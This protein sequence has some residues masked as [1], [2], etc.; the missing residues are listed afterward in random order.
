VHYPLCL[1]VSRRG[2]GRSGRHGVA[3]IV[4]GRA[5]VAI[6]AAAVVISPVDQVTK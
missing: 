5:P 3:V 4:V 6:G 2:R 1:L